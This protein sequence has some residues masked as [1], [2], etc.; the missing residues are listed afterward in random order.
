MR[1]CS[2]CLYPQ[3]H[4]LNITFDDQGICSGCRVHEEKDTLDWNSRLTKLKDILINYKNQS[5]NNYDCIIPVSGAR[6]SFFIVHIIKNVFG[7]NP[8]LVTYNKQ[9]NTD[10][11]IRNLAKL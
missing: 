2:R 10:V 7:M 3:N 4:P 5:Q 9:Y 6:D 1:Y 8:L 11:G